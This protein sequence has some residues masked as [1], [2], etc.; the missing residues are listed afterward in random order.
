MVVVLLLCVWVIPVIGAFDLDVPGVFRNTQRFF[1]RLC[2]GHALRPITLYATTASK[3]P[4][5][6][7]RDA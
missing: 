2:S 6:A 5:D 7:R 3:K 1:H 4:S